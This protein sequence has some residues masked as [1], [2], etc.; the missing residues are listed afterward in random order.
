MVPDTLTN[1]NLHIAG[2]SYAGKV[3]QLQLP[4]LKRKTDAHRGGG[5]DAEVDMAVGLEKLEGGF[6]LTGFDR[7]SLS[8]FGLADGGGFNGTFRGAFTDR[9]G[10]V[11]GVEVDFRGLLTEV[12]MGTWEPGK[13]NETKYNV[14]LDFYKL[15]ADGAVV[16]EIDPLN[17]VRTIGGKDELAAERAALGI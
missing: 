17:N 15:A 16:F 9:R 4:K 11:V 3:S 6:S 2:R 14:S 7:E 13:K 1:M 12:D 8:Y 10:K 5:M